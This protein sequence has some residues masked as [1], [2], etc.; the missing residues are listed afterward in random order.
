MKH[1]EISFYR[2]FSCAMGDCPNTCCKGWRIVFDEETYG[3]YLKE[4]GKNGKRLRGSIRKMDGDVYFK[5]SLRRCPFY[6]RSGLCNLQRTAGTDYIPE[7]CRIF[8]RFRQHYGPFAE[9]TL[10]LSCPTAAHLFLEHVDELVFVESGREIDFERWGTNED[11]AYLDWLCCLREEMLRVL[12]DAKQ[13][14]AHGFGQLL[15]VMRDV[16][17]RCI[18]GEELPPAAELLRAHADAPEF[19]IGAAMTDRLITGGFYHRRLKQVSPKLYALCRRYFHTFDRLN[20]GEADE[21]ADRLRASL[22]EGCPWLEHVLRGYIVYYV[23]M[24]FLEVYEDYS[25]LKKFACGV[26][27]V[28]LLELFLALYFEEAGQLGH[29]ELALLLSVYE[30]RG[31]HN[32]EISESMYRALYPDL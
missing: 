19:L 22:H 15:A 12:R 7:V 14:R 10:F 11:E 5:E 26:M 21:R 9:E 6:E 27:H 1:Y 2:E 17:Q 16:Q 29:G 25:F 13:S 18:G 8:P 4:P 31:R 3:R 32:I 24:V 28:H 20:A 30:R 23:Q